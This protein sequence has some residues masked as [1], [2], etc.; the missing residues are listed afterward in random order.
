MVCCAKKKNK[1]K[2]VEKVVFFLLGHYFSTSED[3]SNI[4]YKTCGLANTLQEQT[5]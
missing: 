1:V 5:A 2:M 4:E 3:L